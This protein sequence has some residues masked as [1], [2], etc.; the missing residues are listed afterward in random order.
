METDRPRESILRDLRGIGY[1]SSYNARGK[2]YTLVNTPVFDDL[3]LWKYQNAYFSIRRTLLDTAE[4]LVNVSSAGYTHDELRQILGIEIQNSLY[5]LTIEGKIV[6]RQISKQ[7]V[8][9]GIESL[10]DQSWK[11][12]TIPIPPVVRKAV[13]TPV[14][15]SYPD[16]DPTLV[17]E[18]L[19]AALRGQET[20]WAAYSYLKRAGSSATAEQVMTVYRHYDIGKKN[21]P[22]QK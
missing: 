8:Y 17:I 7:Y 18:I 4:Y 10:D 3:G 15:K 6:R 20:D 14:T 5:Q 2:F 22:I 19:V 9:F 16:I 11:R 21:S 1:Y 13:K 12:D